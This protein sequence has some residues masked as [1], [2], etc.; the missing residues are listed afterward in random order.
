[1]EQCEKANEKL[2]ERGYLCIYALPPKTM[3]ITTDYL[4][5][6]F[7]D[8]KARFTGKKNIDEM[9]RGIDE[10]ARNLGIVKEEDEEAEMDEEEE[11]QKD[12][13]M[14]VDPKIEELASQ[15]PDFATVASGSGNGTEVAAP[16]I[17]IGG[18]GRYAISINRLL[19]FMTG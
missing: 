11:Q 18:Q 2:T 3:D 7:E 12:V 15:H 9:Q 5:E 16:W 19:Q 4:K 13:V 6:L 17:S 10:C 14:T 1:M 8:S